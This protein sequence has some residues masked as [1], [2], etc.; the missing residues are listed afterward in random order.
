MEIRNIRHKGLRRFFD[1]GDTSGLPPAYVEKIRKML[2]VL[3]HA[4]DSEGIREF[5]I[6]RAHLLTGDRK[7]TWALHVSPTGA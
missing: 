4:S 1:T 5:P 7:G 2:T 6:W 3:S